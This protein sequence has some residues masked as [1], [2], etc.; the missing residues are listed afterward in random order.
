MLDVICGVQHIKRVE[1][2]YNFIDT[3]LFSVNYLLAVRANDAIDIANWDDIRR[4]GKDGIILVT[5]GFGIVDIFE[6]LGGLTIDS[7][8]KTSVA[9]L[10]KLLAGRGR[11]YCHR[12][13]GIKADILKAGFENKVKLI[14]NLQFT[15]QFYMAASKHV[16]NV[17][18][19]K[20]HT[21][22]VTL[23]NNGELKKMFKKYRE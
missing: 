21:A 10:E 22:L 15:E 16:S 2:I 8:G 4:L 23:Q 14:T 17:N 6:N 1:S 19:L 20:I 9:N 12:S 7:G 11:F 13:P 5:H 18:R 3:P